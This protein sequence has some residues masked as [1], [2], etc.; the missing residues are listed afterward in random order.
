MSKTRF[1]RTAIALLVVMIMPAQTS[2]A[3]APADAAAVPENEASASDG[4][5]VVAEAPARSADEAEKEVRLSSEFFPDGNFLAYLKS[6]SE[7]RGVP[8]GASFRRLSWKA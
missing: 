1:L 7:L 5:I 4:V 6:T 8:E 2:L 3:L